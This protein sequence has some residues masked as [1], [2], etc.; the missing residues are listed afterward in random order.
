MRILA[1][2]LKKNIPIDKFKSTYCKPVEMGGVAVEHRSL[3]GHA[4][5]KTK[6]IHA[7]SLPFFPVPLP[8]GGSST[9]RLSRSRSRA[10]LQQAEPDPEL[11]PLPPL[12]VLTRA[13]PKPQ[14]VSPQRFLES[15]GN[16]YDNKGAVYKLT[17]PA[18][19]GRSQTVS[20]KADN[21]IRGPSTLSAI[22]W[23]CLY[24][25]PCLT[26][27]FALPCT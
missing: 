9:V 7:G 13:Q 18:K 21:K 27:V 8:A 24:S 17:L 3:E 16:G 22:V 20:V 25:D 1:S 12:P 4:A 6:K 2:I 11:L 5:K 23:Y 19:D 10:G 15:N 14:Q 26:F